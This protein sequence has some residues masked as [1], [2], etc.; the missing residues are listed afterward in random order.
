MKNHASRRRPI[1][2][3]IA[4]L[5]LVLLFAGPRLGPGRVE[6]ATTPEVR[7]ESFDDSQSPA[8]E[9]VGDVGAGET[10]PGSETDEVGEEGAEADRSAAEEAPAEPE[11][12]Q[13]RQPRAPVPIGDDGLLLNFQ[14]ASLDAVLD[15]LSEAAGLIVLKEVTVE[16]RLSVMSRQPVDVD[17]AVALLN[18]ALKERGYAALRMGRTLKILTLED[19]KT[20]SIPVRYGSEPEE[21]EPTDEV[22]TQVI[23]VR[24]ADAVKLRDDLAPLVPDY[25]QL[26]A[27][28]SSNSLI[29]TDTAANIRRIMEVVRALDT[30]L[31]SVAEVRVFRLEYA[32]A[33]DAANLINT[34][35]QQDEQGGRGQA[36]G[37]P[38]FGPGIFFQRGGTGTQNQAQE[39]AARA[40]RVNAAADDRTNTLVVTG[41]PDTLGIVEEVIKDLDSNPAEEEAVMVYPLKNSQA[42]NVA[43]VLNSLFESTAAQRTTGGRARTQTT[44]QRSSFLARLTGRQAAATQTALAGLSGEVFVVADE[45]TNSL[46]VRTAPKNFELVRTILADLDRPVPQVLIK[47]LIAEVTHDNT[48]DLGLEFSALNLAEGETGSAMFIDFYLSAQTQGFIYR[49]LRGDA[50]AVLRALE[51]IG[52]LEILSR[53]YILASDNQQATITVGDEVPFIR[54]SRTTDTGQ[55]IN[56]IQYEDVGIILYVTP[57]INPDGL[58]IM[59]ISPE[60][61][62]ISGTTVPISETVSA[63]VFAKRSASSRVAIRDGQTIVIGGLIEDGKTSTIRRV[64]ILGSI[65]IFGALFRR[66][67]E[68]KSKTE[69]LIFLTPHVAHIPDDL[70][71]MSKSEVKNARIVTGAVRPG[72]FQR[73]LEGMAGPRPEGEEGEPAGQSDNCW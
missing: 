50:T 15:Y 37:R 32:N 69:L 1:A 49:L 64:P 73:H 21:V 33:R 45:D 14:D 67:I 3:P 7:E 41:P 19:A 61:S 25:A 65:P 5:V 20:A 4:L 38:R 24:Y 12:A 63:A 29:L 58:V 35:F 40:P 2:L 9:S 56:T 30:H 27:N 59:D 72:E 60:I 31:S 47:V 46:L 42:D 68:T 34:I 26:S 44:S 66:T 55:T 52:K 10:E 71:S 62:S 23:P 36:A 51:E 13:P 57:H 16:G 18:S 43:S 48:V 22:I 54:Q 70:A 53:P 11:A 8:P 39:Q 6:G 28:A 17:E